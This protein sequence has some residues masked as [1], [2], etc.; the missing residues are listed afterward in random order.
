MNDISER[1]I[2]IEEYDGSWDS[3]WDLFVSKSNNG[4]IFHKQ[5]FLHYHKEGKFDF[6]HLVIKSDDEVLAL[7]PGGISNSGDQFWSPMGASYG[8]F[9]INDIPFSLSLRIVDKFIEYSSK[10]FKEVFIIPPPIIYNKIY[11]QHIEY[12]MLYRKFDFENHYISHSVDLRKGVDYFNNFDVK[13]RR[14][15]RSIYKQNELRIEESNDFEAFYPILEENKAR[16]NVKPTHSLE[17]LLKL[18]SLLPGELK[19]FMV[20]KREKP[21]AGS[22]L[23]LTNSKVALCFYVMML[24][25]YKHLKPIFLCLNETIK[26]AQHNGY[27]WFDIGVS[28]DTSA[29]DPMT[30]AES[31]IYF[32]E[33]FFARGLLRST[34]H[35]K[36][37]D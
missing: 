24:Y 37:K 29:E 10:R 9:V 19:L 5:A 14:I 1:N 18:N 22:L 8:S 13:A 23:F 33:R 20:Y 6:H 12:A 34:F 15:I 11:N 3:E 21:I 31:L 17:D 26:W 4:T 27:E 35:F 7:L 2:I 36:F 25:E 32:K 28:Q 30:P 16:H